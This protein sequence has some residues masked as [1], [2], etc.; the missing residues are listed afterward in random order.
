M[1]IH[2]IHI[3]IYIY[4][5]YMYIYT[6]RVHLVNLSKPWSWS[7]FPLGFDMACCV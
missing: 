7:L 6:K 5:T 4:I 3:Y 1:K 2:I